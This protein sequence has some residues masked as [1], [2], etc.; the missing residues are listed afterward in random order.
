[1]GNE[2]EWMFYEQEERVGLEMFDGQELRVEV[3]DLSAM[4]RWVSGRAASWA[5][6]SGSSRDRR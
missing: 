3:K 5:S 2:S 6:W 1:M 4:G